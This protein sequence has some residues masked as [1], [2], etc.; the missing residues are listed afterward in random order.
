[1]TIDELQNFLDNTQV[2]LNKCQSYQSEN[3]A[4][5]EEITNLK[6][7][8]AKIQEENRQL[9]NNIELLETKYKNFQERAKTII[10]KF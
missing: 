1:M 7:T 5:K 4:L 2:V 6:D 8:L 10:N 9:R 3:S